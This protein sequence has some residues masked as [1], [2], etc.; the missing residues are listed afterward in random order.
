MKKTA[1]LSLAALALMAT[2]C[3]LGAGTGTT[4]G[5]SSNSAGS[6]SVLG[7]IL[8]A[9]TNG[10]TIGN[11]LQ[12]VLGLDKVTKQSLI[13]T[14]KYHQPG[15]AFTSENLLAQAGGEAVATSIKQ[16]LSG[17]YQTAGIKQS[18]TQITFKDDGTFAATIAGKSWQGTWTYDEASYKISMKGLLLNV[19]CYAKHNTNGVGL[20]FEA[21][22][23]LTVMQT[24]TALSG[25]QTAQTIGDLSKNYNGL[26]VGFEMTK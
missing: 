18:N 7:S 10:E 25:N 23:L 16:K 12:S 13:G 8:S 24:L 11:V 3:G 19:N 5:T 26:R 1:I 9:A 14:W 6:G 22:K 21:S 15:C 20:L 17:Y 4:S 2:G